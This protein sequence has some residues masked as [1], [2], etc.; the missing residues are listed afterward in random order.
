MMNMRKFSTVDIITAH[1]HQLCIALL[2]TAVAGC[3]GARSIPPRVFP[4]NIVAHPRGTIGVVAPGERPPLLTALRALGVPYHHLSLKDFAGLDL[5][6]YVV[7]ILDEGAL[8]Y[9]GAAPAYARMLEHTTRTGGTLIVLNQPTPALRQI[10][11]RLPLKLVP[12]DIDYRIDLA[13]PR[14]DDPVTVQPNAITRGNLDS[15]A[16]KT[17]QLVYGGRDARALIAANLD[18]PDSSA[19]LLWEPVGKGTVWYLAVPVA[20]Y[21][22]AGYEAEQK[23]VANLVSNK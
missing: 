4:E 10:S 13:L 7:M 2:L 20:G 19:A 17:S 3:G 5:T 6:P 23:V 16:R 15:L 9:D 12:R 14:R 22:A 21:A 1:V 11:T 8:E 18:A